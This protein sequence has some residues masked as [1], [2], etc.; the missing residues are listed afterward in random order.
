MSSWISDSY[1]LAEFLNKTTVF[2]RRHPH[3]FSVALLGTAT[4]LLWG[5]SERFDQGYY[6]DIEVLH[7]QNIR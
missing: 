4:L 7:R 3:S 1:S 6:F 5:K 2:L